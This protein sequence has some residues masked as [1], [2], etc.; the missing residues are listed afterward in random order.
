[1]KR[2]RVSGR[3]GFAASLVLGLIALG[4]TPAAASPLWELV[5]ATSSLHPHSASTFSS[6]ASATY[7][8]PA[9][10][11]GQARHGEMG[12]FGLAG[13]LRIDLNAR[14]AGADIGEE[15]YQA[16]E[17][18]ENGQR[19]PLSTRPFA[20]DDIP[21]SRGS[22]N[23]DVE[24]L[25]LT[26]G[27]SL[28]ILDEDRLTVGFY[29]TL[30]TDGFAS[31]VPFYSDEREQ[32][33]SNSLYFERFNDRLVGSHFALAL[34][35]RPLSWLSVGVG[36]TMVQDAASEN[37]I[38]LPD[39]LDQSESR[40]NSRVQVNARLAPYG[41]L[42]A[43]VG[44]SIAAAL[45]VHAESY[46][47]VEGESRLRFW[48][49][50]SAYP[51][52]EDA[53]V[54][55]FRFVYDYEPWRATAGASLTHTLNPKTELRLAAQLHYAHWSRYLDRHA[56]R[57]ALA[58]RNTFSPALA[59]GLTRGRSELGLDLKW[60]PSPVPD[61]KGR[62]NY[63][64]NDRLVV[65]GG[66]AWRFEGGDAMPSI[67]LG[68]QL[69]A[70]WLLARQTT[71]DPSSEEPVIDEFPDAVD[72]RSG[73]PVEG[74]RGLQTNNPGYPGFEAAGWLGGATVFVRAYF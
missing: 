2:V 42:R 19:R 49:F 43:Q 18:D 12:V 54:Q 66:Y 20:T 41:G 6:S 11:V 34:A 56:E 53:V 5:G 62:S 24:H 37:A 52:G 64:D 65:G 8:N 74:S 71:K 40:I 46:S 45:S 67:E 57:P 31:Q 50:P 30:A 68:A 32:Y 72:S 33:F 16:R 59:A 44:E 69:Q 25:Y 9:L 51:E 7:F 63:V 15:V 60:A 14:P 55:R 21:A 26:L 22:A 61:Q 27:A 3:G 1:M 23:S 38:F 4:A 10:L 47:E 58:W 48:N 13:R 70:H 29:A 35:S 28:P 73:E 17:L 39:A 36:A